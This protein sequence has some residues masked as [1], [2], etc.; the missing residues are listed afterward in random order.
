MCLPGFVRFDISQIADVALGAIGPTVVLLR[1]I[2]VRTGRSSVGRG[3][4][5]LF[6]DMKTVCAG[7]EI[8]DVPMNLH[9]T[10]RLCERDRARSLA[11]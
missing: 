8:F 5:P 1:W 7:R 3:T 4:I 2:K 6:V 9:V 10:A 11:S